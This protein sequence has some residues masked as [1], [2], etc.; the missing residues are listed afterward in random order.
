MGCLL[1]S[2][3]VRGKLAGTSLKSVRLEFWLQPV[4]KNLGDVNDSRL[5]TGFQPPEWEWPNAPSSPR[6]VA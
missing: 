2:R 1:L 3:R 6:Y 4:A 5:K